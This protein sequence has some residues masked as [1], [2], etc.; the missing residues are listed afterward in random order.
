MTPAQAQ[1]AAVTNDEFDLLKARL[2]TF[3]ASA[4]RD[5]AS[6][7][8]EQSRAAA[9]TAVEATVVEVSPPPVARQVI[10]VTLDASGNVIGAQIV[11]DALPAT[12]LAPLPAPVTM[13]VRV[14]SES[15]VE[16]TV[17]APAPVATPDPAPTPD[18]AVEVVEP[19]VEV[20]PATPPP[21]FPAVPDAP[22]DPPATA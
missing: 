8:L 6:S 4:D 22:A 20:D 9:L 5:N 10:Q 14:M 7:L 3:P 18:P 13:P 15:G 1:V 17:E 16:R 2:D 11:H 19:V 21:P 12:P